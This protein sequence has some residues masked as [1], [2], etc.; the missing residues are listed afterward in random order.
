M[1]ER[2]EGERWLSERGQRQRGTESILRFSNYCS[3]K[4][5]FDGLTVAF[6]G[7]SRTHCRIFVAYRRDRS[8]P[9]SS[10]LE[11]LFKG[12]SSIL[13]CIRLSVS[14]GLVT[15]F[16][17]FRAFNEFGQ[18]NFGKPLVNF[19]SKAGIVTNTQTELT[20]YHA[21]HHTCCVTNIAFDTRVI[22]FSIRSNHAGSKWSFRNRYRGMFRWNESVK[23][24]D[25]RVE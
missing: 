17:Y 10:K 19:Y 20:K 25:Q 13:L 6:R 5:S 2:S 8:L 22:E 24:L 12:S 4:S 21:K 1:R 16:R 18:W 3:R 15:S 23:R 14:I 7:N 11:Y 9:R